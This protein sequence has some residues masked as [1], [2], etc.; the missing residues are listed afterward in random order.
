MSI[1]VIMAVY[2]NEH[3]V[4]LAVRSI[5]SQEI[6]AFE[7]VIVDDGSTDSTIMLLEQFAAEDRRIVLLRN[8]GNQGRAHARNRAI[9]AARYPFIAILDADDIA[10]PQRLGNQ[11]AFMR[12][13]PDIGLLGAGHIRINDHNQPIGMVP[14][15]TEDHAIRKQFRRL[16]M[17]FCHST[18]CFRRSIL[19]QTGLY[20]PRFVRGQDVH[21]CR[22]VAAV[23]R[24]AALPELLVLYRVDNAPGAERLRD[25]YRWS[26]YA[27]WDN[28]RRY[29][30][31]T[32]LVNL[33][34]LVMLGNLP[35]TIAAAYGRHVSRMYRQAD[36]LPTEVMAV[37]EWVQQLTLEIPLQC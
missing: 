27:A 28:L 11:L 7:L 3:D 32:G 34:R 2:N 14:C 33:L 18:V 37:G 22:R 19:E 24:T 17:P 10:L 35:P 25:K 6:E 26:A 20:D 31:L 12:D 5:L 15:P 1:S 9:K 13:H 36:T 21:L 8:A 23:T 29:P 30:S 16:Q 4:G